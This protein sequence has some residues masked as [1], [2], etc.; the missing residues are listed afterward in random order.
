MLTRTV[1]PSQTDYASLDSVYKLILPFQLAFAERNGFEPRKPFDIAKL[2]ANYARPRFG[3]EFD[4]DPDHVLDHPEFWKH[5]GKP[6]AISAHPYGPVL[7]KAE[8]LARRFGLRVQ[9]CDRSWYN[10]GV[11][12]LVVI[13]A[14]DVIVTLPTAED[15]AEYARVHALWDRARGRVPVNNVI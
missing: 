2:G 1:I 12:S 5:D 7:L 10:P 4:R 8:R 15:A 9:C 14:P 11:S 13:T 6:I 3:A